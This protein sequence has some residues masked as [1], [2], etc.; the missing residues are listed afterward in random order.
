MVITTTTAA[1]TTNGAIRKKNLPRDLAGDTEE[2][3]LQCLQ[4][5]KTEDFVSS[6]QI[7]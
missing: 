6:A 4:K 3:R 1:T 7:L 2:N 5:K